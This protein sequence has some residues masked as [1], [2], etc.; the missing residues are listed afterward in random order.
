M[1]AGNTITQLDHI[2]K[3]I[4]PG[5]FVVAIILIFTEVIVLRLFDV[6]LSHKAGAVS[7]VSGMFVFGFEAIADFLFYL[8]IAYWLYEHRLF[9]LSFK[10]YVWVLC[11]VLYDLMFYL[12]HRIQHRVRLL[13]CFHS[14]H[15]SSNEMRLSSAVRGSMFD[16]IYTPPFF[17]WMCLFGIHPLM[18]IAVRS[19]SRIWGILEHLNE[20]LLGRTPAWLNKIFI[21]PDV[22]RV[23]HGKNYQYLDRNYSEIFSFWDRLFGTYEEFKQQPDYGI[24]KPV[25]TESF[26]AIQFGLFKDLIKD[27]QETKGWKNKLKLLYMPPGWYP[28][29]RDYRAETLRKMA[30]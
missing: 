6:K 16:F 10:W 21:T 9:D 20:N 8:A 3:I 11:F 17:I 7:L 18:F 26:F 13:W 25:D 27:V 28:D 1:Q 5:L 30:V 22:H 24:L 19:I 2:V 14:T 23:H 29:G 4:Q 15:H 12:S